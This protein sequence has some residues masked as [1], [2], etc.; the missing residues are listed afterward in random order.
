MT[1]L[2]WN[3]V[4]RDFD[5]GM[6]NALTGMDKLWPARRGINYTRLDLI[7]QDLI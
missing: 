7:T 3:D 1:G 6:R 2:T 4:I 5:Q